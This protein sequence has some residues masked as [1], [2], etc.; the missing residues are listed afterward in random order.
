MFTK[1][2]VTYIKKVSN[3]QADSRFDHKFTIHI[4]SSNN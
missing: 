4:V 1:Y 3:L 2:S